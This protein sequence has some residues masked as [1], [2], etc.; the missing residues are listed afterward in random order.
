MLRDIFENHWGEITFGPI[1]QGAA[2]EMRAAQAPAAIKMFDGYLTV[3]FGVPH[4][5]ICIGE[6][7]GPHNNRVSPDLAHHRRT[8]RAELYRQL[9]RDGTPVSVGIA[10]LQRQG[11]A[12]DHGP[13]TQPVPAS[14]DGQG[15]AQA[16]LVAARFV[17][18]VTGTLAWLRG[19]RPVRPIRHRLPPWLAN[20][21]GCD[22]WSMVVSAM[23]RAVQ[24]DP[25]PRARCF[26]PCTSLEETRA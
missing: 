15:L 5:H 26:N 4:F 14:R 13:S 20:H 19:A 25:P 9:S 10:P 8:A 12:A 24:I 11:R 18:Q 6:H 21:R 16:R 2:W 3:A 22:I 7:K 1:I 23:H 17:G